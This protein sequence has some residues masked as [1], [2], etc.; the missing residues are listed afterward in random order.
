MKR[1]TVFFVVMLI[2]LPLAACAAAT[3]QLAERVMPEAPMPAPAAQ[4]APA[5]ARADSAGGASLQ[6]PQEVAPDPR[7]IVYT[8]N[9]SMVVKDPAQS[10][11]QI[12]TL[13]AAANGYVSQSQLYQY[14]GD[15]MR[16]NVTLRVPVE[17][18]QS[19]LNQLK[20][21][22]VRVL[23]ENSNAN[24]VTAEYTD[25]EAQ[26]RNLEAAEKELQALLTE[27][28]ERPGATAEDILN[29]YNALAEKRGEIEQVKGR[30]QY[31]SNQVALSTITA[32][33]VPDE[34]TK[35]IVEEGWQPLVTLKNA[36]RRLVAVMQGL[37]DVAINLVV[38]V[39]PL[40]IV[41]LVPIVLLVLVIRWWRRRRRKAA[42][43]AS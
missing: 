31:L 32:D 33:L 26:L 25:L 17:N 43:P 7:K 2:V 38:V 22:A 3:P 11:E 39:L 27:V 15:Q 12:R 9:V 42:Q 8:A 4:P 23:T 28:R 14:T 34:I 35:P 21:M 37:V 18:Y 5:G 36:F 10:I 16:G 30:L 13:A 24:D 29:V 19:V 20:A 40:A 41:L 1:A 6:L